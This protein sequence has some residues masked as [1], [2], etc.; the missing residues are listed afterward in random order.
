MVATPDIS[1]GRLPKDVLDGRFTDIKPHLDLHEARIAADR[2]LFCWDAPCVKACPTTIDV[3]LFIRQIATDNRLGAARTILS[4][5]I[6]GGTCARVCPTETLCEEACVRNASEARPVEIGR[7]Q[8]FATEAVVEVGRQIF[9]RAPATGRHVAVVGAGPAGLS[10]AH[11]LARRGHDVTIFEAAAKPGGLSEYG[12]AAYKETDDFARTEVDWILGIGG[13][14][15]QYGVRIGVDLA[16][17]DLGHR[18]DA[19]FLGVGLGDTNGLGLGDDL[20]GVEDAVAWIA[21]LRQAEDLS[22]VP[23]GRR[24]VVIGGGMTAI[25]AASQAKRLGAEE[26][27]IAYRRGL[28]EMG[29]SDHEKD[30]ART[31]GVSIRTNLKPTR[32]IGED[33]RVVAIELERTIVESGRVVGTGET[34]TLPCDQVFRAIGQTLRSGDLGEGLALAGGRIVVDAEGRT[35]LPR[36]WAGGDCTGSGE[37]LTVEAVAAGKTAALSIDRALAAAVAA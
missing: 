3:P 33:G 11:E 9:T 7:L 16:F 19:I 26:V 1:A 36:V 20:A 37:D 4:S 22:E 35:S 24:V 2:C 34:I 10:A 27:T 14:T 30:I 15:I 32:L 23:V 25:D 31:D 17:A 13:I 6:L 18:Y 8:R 21:A 28:A 29:A 12:L 5:N